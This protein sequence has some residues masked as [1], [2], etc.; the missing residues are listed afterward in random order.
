[1]V[2]EI[3][4]NTKKNRSDH[5][6]GHVQGLKKGPTIFFFGGIHGNE[7][8][9][10]IAMEKV[11]EQLGPMTPNLRGN[12]FG[13]KGNIAALVQDKRFLKEDLNRMWTEKSIASILSKTDGERTIEEKEL[14]NIYQLVFE[15]LEQQVPPYYFI[16][17]HTT[18]SKTL[19]FITINDA[20]INRNFAKLF[21]LPIIL[22]IEEF[23][24]GPLLSFMNEKG[25]VSLGF[26]S[27]QHDEASAIAN[28][29]AFI[30]LVLANAG[31]LEKNRG[32]FHN[33]YFEQ[34]RNAARDNHKIYEVEKRFALAQNDQFKMLPGF[35][36]FQRVRKGTVLGVLNEKE[37]TTKKD[38]ILFMPLYQKQGV[39]G[40]FIIRTIPKWALKL[41]EFLRN[42]KADVLLAALPGIKWSDSGKESLMVNLKIARFYAKSIFHLLGYRNRKIDKTNVIIE[43]RERKARTDMYRKE[44][45]F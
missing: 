37:I 32:H 20:L 2:K 1:M 28:A 6:I 25:Y 4:L 12:L 7:K 45:W 36:S 8:A 23:L 18:S 22:G 16:D 29:M 35:E 38:L 15:L 9:G 14:F 19:P 43:N 10:L 5:L 11:F 42:I 27:G 31:V 33:L 41:S 17:F 13:I 24:E 3:L 30:W 44:P 26:E 39:E 21:P 34:L 40:F